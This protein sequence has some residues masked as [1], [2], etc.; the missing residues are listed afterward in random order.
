MDPMGTGWEAFTNP[1][2]DE[3]KWVTM[4]E[5]GDIL[6]IDVLGVLHYRMGITDDVQTGIAWKTVENPDDK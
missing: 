4:C 2:A 1:L 6:A 5:N 3:T